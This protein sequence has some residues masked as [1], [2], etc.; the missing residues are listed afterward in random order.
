MG[1][2]KILADYLS[3]LC[4]SDIPQ[5]A[6]EQA[7]RLLTQ[8]IAISYEGGRTREAEVLRSL[9]CKEPGTAETCGSGNYSPAFSALADGVLA[10]ALDWEDC[11]W[12]GHPSAGIVPVAWILGQQGK[13]TGKELVTAIVGAYDVYHRIAMSI[14]PTPQEK[15]DNGWGLMSW[16]LFGA[17]AAGAKVL[18]FTSAEINQA[19]TLAA[20]TT[21]LPTSLHDFTLSNGYHFEHGMRN[22]TT[23]NILE[24]VRSDKVKELPCDGLDRYE[25]FAV[26]YTSEWKPE[27]LTR[28]L[29]EHFY[30]M[31]TMLKYYPGNMWIIPAVDAVMNIPE[32]IRKSLNPEEIEKI[33]IIPGTTGRMKTPD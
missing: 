5:E 24:Y 13:V 14:Q 27:W 29:G 31:D 21:V 25:D 9:N 10:D 12:T 23:V 3:N 28:E 7:V 30:I 15:K 1:Y 19:L 8:V 17:V 26:H 18:D 6:S 20:A 22:Y 33:V 2:T 11:A 16:Q 4:Y 32:N